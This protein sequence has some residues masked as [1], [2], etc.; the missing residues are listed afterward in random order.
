MKKRLRSWLLAIAIRLLGTPAAP[1]AT[2]SPVPEPDL[3][4]N[5]NLIP[6]R[7]AL[8]RAWGLSVHAR[9][10]SWLDVPEVRNGSLRQ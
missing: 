4:L 3:R 1:S 8:I 6:L 10:A 5:D 2:V 7:F 9:N